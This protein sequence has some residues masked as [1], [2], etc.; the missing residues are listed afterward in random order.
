MFHS[1]LVTYKNFN[2]KI[3]KNKKTFRSLIPFVGLKNI[4]E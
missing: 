2:T 1:N 4:S 3:N